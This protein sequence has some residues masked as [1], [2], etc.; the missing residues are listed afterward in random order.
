[1][2][3][4]VIIIALVSLF[5]SCAEV[6]KEVKDENE[7]LDSAI[8]A[9][10]ESI[11]YEQS[12]IHLDENLNQNG[13]L[14]YASLEEIKSES[15][16]FLESNKLNVRA[17]T[18]L[19]DNGDSMPAYKVEPYNKN[20]DQLSS[21]VKYLYNEEFSLSSKNCQYFKKE[22]D[23]EKISS[24]ENTAAHDNIIYTGALGDQTQSLVYHETG[25]SFYNAVP[26]SDQFRSPEYFPTEKIYKIR[27]G[28]K[29]DDAS[30]CMLDDLKW[31]V[32]EA[33]DYAQSFI[34]MYIAP[35]EKNEFSYKITDFK[36]KKLGDKY[37]YV[38]DFKRID[39]NGN[40][41]DNHEY[42]SIDEQYDN[43]KNWI[44]EK[45]P[46]IYCSQ[47]EVT[48][49]KKNK[50]N[51]YLKGLTPYHGEVI[52]EGKSLLTLESAMSIISSKMAN[53]KSYRFETVE[54]EYYYV[55]MNC[56]STNF[57]SVQHLLCDGSDIQARPY[58]AFTMKD[59]YPDVQS[60]DDISAYDGMLFLVDAVTGEMYIY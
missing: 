5:T 2:R 49:T 52:N 42:Y 30:Y 23:P 7:I 29:L 57:K 48:M 55:A 27:I 36:V 43:S 50:I 54:L 41:Y 26:M 33:A 20:F 1:M 21:I 14:K 59:C 37:G 34:D 10:T 38:V 25:Y 11:N 32:K 53:Q 9:N 22:T 12:S 3:I 35:L 16:A 56:A 28:E 40:Q 13:K 58:W 15:K 51:S 60:F 24:S 17:D 18:L 45:V 47:I 8:V 6:P 4:G 46:Y 31:S 44:Q 39:K 19:I